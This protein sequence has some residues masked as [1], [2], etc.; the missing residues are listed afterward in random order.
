MSF[1]I[2]HSLE[3]QHDLPFYRSSFWHPFSI[4]ILTYVSCIFFWTKTLLPIKFDK[5]STG[6]FIYMVECVQW[7]S[8]YSIHAFLQPQGLRVFNHLWQNVISRIL[9]DF[10]FSQPKSI[11]EMTESIC[12]QNSTNE[13]IFICAVLRAAMDTQNE[14]FNCKL[15]S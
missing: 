12:S 15:D 1:Y 6:T 3:K 13:R 5:V 10:I 7:P 4:P 9:Y 8:S 14:E 11:E 2:L